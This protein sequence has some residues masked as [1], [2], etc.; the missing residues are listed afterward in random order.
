MD[1]DIVVASRRP[2]RDSRCGC[3]APCGVV[4]TYRTTRTCEAST[5]WTWTSRR[6]GAD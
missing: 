5:T 4:R 6:G 2:P 1:A 3:R